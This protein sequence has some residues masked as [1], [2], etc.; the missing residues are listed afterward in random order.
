M[1][2][3]LFSKR[4]S[5]ETALPGSSLSRLVV[6][7]SA[8]LVKLLCSTRTWAPMRELIPEVGQSSKQEL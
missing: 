8:T 2:V 4:L 1:S 3:G 7:A 6:I 5:V